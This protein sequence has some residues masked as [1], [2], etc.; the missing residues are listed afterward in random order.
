M[1]RPN[2]FTHLNYFH[3]LRSGRK[4]SCLGLALFT[5]LRVTQDRTVKKT[6]KSPSVDDSR[7]SSVHT[8]LKSIVAFS[9]R[10]KPNSYFILLV[11]ATVFIHHRFEEI[12]HF[13]AYSEP[14]D[15]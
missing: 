10:M 11:S 7:P 8:L 2:N 4:L 13:I 1:E 5:A 6:S 3:S 12:N 9:S 15:A 14:W